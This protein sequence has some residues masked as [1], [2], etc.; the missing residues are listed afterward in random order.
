MSARTAIEDEVYRVAA[1]TR[2]MEAT[3]QKVV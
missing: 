1:G 3:G 2:V